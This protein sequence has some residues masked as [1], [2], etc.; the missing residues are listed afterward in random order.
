MG[1][2]FLII[3]L[4][5]PVVRTPKTVLA[6]NA[7]IQAVLAFVIEGVSAIQASNALGNH[8]LVDQVSEQAWFV[9]T[10]PQGKSFA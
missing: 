3:S 5:G 8:L 7:T 6:I 10:E 2:F 1:H 4:L 9:T